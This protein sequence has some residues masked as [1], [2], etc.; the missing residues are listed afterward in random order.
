MGLFFSPAFTSCNQCH[1]LQ[2]VYSTKRESFSNYRYENIGVPANPKLNDMS[3]MGADWVDEGLLT[4]LL[5]ADVADED[6]VAQRGKFKVPT[7]RN[8][9]IT[10]PYMHNGVFKDLRTVVL[11]YNKYNSK[12]VQAQTNPETQLDWGPPLVGDNIATEKLSSLFL[13]DRQVDALMAFLYMLTDE[14]YEHL[15]P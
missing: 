9:A 6:R 14:R 11:F 1:Q 5:L 10:A 8:A 13:V 12:N 2:S 7:L 4:T 3:E 15:L